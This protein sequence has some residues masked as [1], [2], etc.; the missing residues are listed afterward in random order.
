M[1]VLRGIPS[2]FLPDPASELAA[3][4]L[5]CPLHEANKNLAIAAKAQS[6]LFPHP[7]AFLKKTKKKRIKRIKE[8]SFIYV[9]F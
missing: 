7:S 5:P 8:T 4:Y 2:M 9:R 6:A 3:N 1:E